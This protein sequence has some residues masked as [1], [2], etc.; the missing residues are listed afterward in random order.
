MKKK[1][2]LNFDN[3]SKQIFLKHL[4]HYNEVNIKI[5]FLFE[6]YFILRAHFNSDL[7]HFE[8]E[9]RGTPALLE[10]ARQRGGDQCDGRHSPGP[11]LLYSRDSQ[12]GFI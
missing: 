4:K 6:V 9:R 2:E 7:P 12:A 8:F 3:L 11:N 1:S 10:H 5:R